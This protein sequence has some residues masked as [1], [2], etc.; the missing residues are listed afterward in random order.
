MS[1]KVTV[2]N[3]GRVLPLNE[4]PAHPSAELWDSNKKWN[5]INF[6]W[7]YDKLAEHLAEADTAFAKLSCDF[8]KEDPTKLAQS[9]W[10]RGFTVALSMAERGELVGVKLQKVPQ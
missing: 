4:N 5:P 8:K 6:S 2:A 1:K 9:A 7:R 10:A 3:R